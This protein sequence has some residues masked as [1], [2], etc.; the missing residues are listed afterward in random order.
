[1]K[2][3]V[4]KI[5]LRESLI[6][7]INE[8]DKNDSNKNPNYEKDY[9]EIQRKLDGTMLKAS[10]VMSAAGLGDPN[11][12]TDRSLFSKKLRKETNTEGGKYLFDEKE[13]SAVMRVL[14]NPSS[15]L[16]VKKT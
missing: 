2:K 8:E 7:I 16:S 4:I 9:S 11:N 6:K 12:A 14:N 15:Y 13:L 3:E 5:K 10:Q 1:M